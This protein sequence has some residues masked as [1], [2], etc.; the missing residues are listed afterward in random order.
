MNSSND[1]VVS[2]SLRV[3]GAIMQSL[4]AF[5]KWPSSLCSSSTH[6]N[7]SPSMPSEQQLPH[8]HVGQQQEEQQAVGQHSLQPSWLDD[9]AGLQLPAVIS[10]NPSGADTITPSAVGGQHNSS[11]SSS[12]LQHTSY[13][14]IDTAAVADCMLA[15]LLASASA[16][17]TPPPAHAADVRAGALLELQQVMLLLADTAPTWGRC[18][19]STSNNTISCCHKPNTPNRPAG[20]FVAAGSDELSWLQAAVA[21]S[22][23]ALTEAQPS[24][25]RCVGRVCGE[26]WTWAGCRLHASCKWSL[27]SG[28]EVHVDKGFCRS[29]LLACTAYAPQPVQCIQPLPS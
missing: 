2:A 15:M 25:R 23:E 16:Q 10:D 21:V 28:L 12:T 1:A 13:Q 8:Q 14:S 4:I 18:S 6:S 7:D 26:L 24:V 27:G 3:A 29:F 5:R 19:C 17:S 9:G 22:M 11:G 20:V